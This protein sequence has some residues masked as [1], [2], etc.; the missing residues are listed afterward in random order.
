MFQARRIHAAAFPIV[1]T[2]VVST[3]SMSRSHARASR[4]GN[5]G[6]NVQDS[7]I[8]PMAPD[9]CGPDREGRG[10]SAVQIAE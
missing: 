7:S 5:T 8:I 10:P 6:E 3:T 9:P 2:V 4:Q 1:V